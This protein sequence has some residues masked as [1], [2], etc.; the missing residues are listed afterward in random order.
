MYVD[1]SEKE[2]PNVEE[3]IPYLKKIGCIPTYTYLEM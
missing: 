2:A 3:V 1:A